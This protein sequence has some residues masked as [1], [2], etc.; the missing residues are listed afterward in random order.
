MKRIGIFLN[1]NPSAG[2]IYQYAISILDALYLSDYDVQILYDKRY[3]NKEIIKYKKKF[4]FYPIIKPSFINKLS[5]FLLISHLPL[6][7]I[8]LIN[9]LLNPNINLIKKL[10]CDFWLYPYPDLLSYQMGFRY[11][12]PIHDLMHI[13]EKGFPEMSS[14]LRSKIRDKRFQNICDNADAILV[15]SNVGKKHLIDSYIVESEKVFILPFVPPDYI[16]NK[17]ERNSAIINDLNLPKKYLF[18]PAKF[19]EHKNHINLLRALKLALDRFPD[20]HFVFTGN[21]KFNYKKIINEI[22]IL[23][24]GTSVT[25]LGEI[26]L[27]L[28]PDVYK[29][30]SGLFMPTFGGPTNIPPLEAIMCD[31]P[32]AVSKIYGMPEQLKRASIFF[33]PHS[34]KEMSDAICVLWSDKK[35][36]DNL[37]K[38]GKKYKAQISIKSHLVRIE[39]IINNF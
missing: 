20:I 27:N 7:L 39:K 36:T 11:I 32:P 26:N 6:P 38:E 13:Y 34:I 33:N 28:M 5:K 9:K 29:N 24:L 8:R 4:R 21:K 37:L 23:N 10:N 17:V 22:E 19:W 25:I 14:F 31:C 3:W 12:A 1:L 15:D 16:R 35:T 2:G 30:S 18:Y